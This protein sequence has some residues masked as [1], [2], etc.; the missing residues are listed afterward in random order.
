MPGT[1]YAVKETRITV[2]SRALALLDAKAVTMEELADER[3]L[4]L[5]G[6]NVRL[7]Y[8]MALRECLAENNWAFART[9]RRLEMVVYH[10][11]AEDEDK[12]YPPA[13]DS[14][15]EYQYKFYYPPEVVEVRAILDKNYTRLGPTWE[16]SQRYTGQ[17]GTVQKKPWLTSGGYIYADEDEVI[18]EYTSLELGQDQTNWPAYFDEAFVYRLAGSCARKLT[19]SQTIVNDMWAHYAENIAKAKNLEAKLEGPRMAY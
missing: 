2:A 9:R 17:L 15:G 8:N 7:F 11:T 10:D 6:K 4:S 1:G 12:P 19:G 16:D 14:Y 5:E 13:R 3:R 18:M